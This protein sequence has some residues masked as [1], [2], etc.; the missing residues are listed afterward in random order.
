MQPDREA[1]REAAEALPLAVAEAARLA[2][3]A[4]VSGRL[5]EVRADGRAGCATRHVATPANAP[6]DLRDEAHRLR[7]DR[8]DAMV[9][10]LASRLEDDAPCPVCGSLDH[11]DPSEVR[12]DRVT[13]YQEEAAA[14]AAEAA[15]EAADALGRDLAAARALA[16]DLG[17]RLRRL[18]APR[19]VAP[20]SGEP[21]DPGEPADATGSAYRRSLLT[22]SQEDD[23]TGPDPAGL[24]A[25]ATAAAERVAGLSARAG[26]LA[27]LDEALAGLD[28]QLAELEATRAA[29]EEQRVAAAR[30][31][32]AAAERAAAG[33][34][35][36]AERLDGAPDLAA[37]LA[38]SAEG[39]D[40]L[41]AAAVAADG[42]AQA[43]EHELRCRE[44]ALAAAV[45]AGFAD[46]AAAEAAAR[47]GPWRADAAERVAAPPGRR[48]RR[49]RG[50][51]RPRPRGPPRRRPRTSPAPPR[52]PRRRRRPTSTRSDSSPRRASGRSNSPTSSRARCPV[53]PARPARGTRRRGSR[54]WPTWPPARARTPAG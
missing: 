3:A 22:P 46:A 49:D 42:L 33:R 44:A 40:A 4:D 8:F 5:A 41:A 27:A 37:A 9:A 29:A 36:L 25:A 39:A 7:R 16:A 14:T 48:R 17:T 6:Q 28:A 51:R 43:R 20:A 11:P 31:A 2:E 54:R 10:E 24:A 1:A 34:R 26:E 32:A 23:Y 35:T 53:R 19:S 52:P 18:C 30:D 38:A 13:H 21:G 12:A 47:P 15:R 45:E 50:A